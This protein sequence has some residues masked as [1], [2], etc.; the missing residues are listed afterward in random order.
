VGIYVDIV[1]GSLVGLELIYMI[2]LR[3]KLDRKFHDLKKANLIEK[4][5]IG[6]LRL[7]C[8][9]REVVKCLIESI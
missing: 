6:R 7:E 1:R 2:Y 8:I 4:I 5:K 9:E 3:L